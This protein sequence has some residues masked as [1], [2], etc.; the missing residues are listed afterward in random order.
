[1]KKLTI[2][3]IILFAVTIKTKAQ[4]AYFDGSG[5]RIRVLDASPVNTSAVPAAYQVT[6]KAI[7][8]EAWIYPM[9]L[10]GKSDAGIL[11]Y[12]PSSNPEPYRSF[13]LRVD[14]W[15]SDNDDPRIQWIISDGTVPVNWGATLDPNKPV[16]GSWTHVAGTYDGSKLC[17]YIN[18]NLVSQSAYSSD[19]GAGA[20]GLY[21]GGH[22]S[23]YFNGLIDEVRLW[24]VV[25]SQGQIQASMN[26]ILTGSETGLVGYWPMD[27]DYTTDAGLKAV[28][29]KTANHNDLLVQ[30]DAKLVAFPQGVQPQLPISI[31]TYSDWYAV[32]GIK[33]SS[34]LNISG[35]PTPT[36]SMLTK[37][38][39]MV[40]TGDSLFWTPQAYQSKWNEVF[41]Q[42]NNN[43][44]SR[45]KRFWV[46]VDQLTK[47]QNQISLDV[48]Y[49]GNL[50]GMGKYAKGLYYKSLNGLYSA[51]FSLVDRL[52]QKFAGCL[53]NYG[54][55]AFVPIDVFTT[56]SSRFPGFTAFRNT[57]VDSNEKNRM[58]VQVVQTIHSSTA[59]N[60]DKYAI[61]EYQVTNQSGT[62]IPDLF[63][64]LTADFDIGVSS[65]NLGG[66][67]PTLKLTYL[68]ES[69]GAT[70]PYYYGFALLNNP[71]SG[72]SVFNWD[73][74][75]TYI[76]S[77]DKLT[78]IEPNPTTPAEYRNQLN[79]GPYQ[80]AN[81]ASRTFAFALLAGDELNDIKYSATRAANVF[82]TY[83]ALDEVVTDNNNILSLSKNYP[84]PFNN[85]TK[86]TYTIAHP[87][88]ASLKVFD[89]QGK[90]VA[91][92]FN[93]FVASGTYSATIKASNIPSGMY[94]YKLESEGFVVTKRLVVMK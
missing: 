83:T 32:T 58:G 64:Q 88:I 4:S 43:S 46:Y 34:G 5:D 22:T 38:S 91:V 42:A 81:G 17:L 16:V 33:F 71:V 59:T 82:N 90:E 70:N 3:L 13:E 35:W 72:A 93:Q 67:D 12:R 9:K 2:I 84:N 94:I 25:R 47:A 27:A 68:Y 44:N 52:T 73:Y 65:N 39:G 23:Q 51:N 76:R 15:W 40:L 11:V 48:S 77:L 30:Y 78:A 26:Q 86:I 56:V 62:T 66:Y 89:L 10:P 60:D 61:L 57:L 50:G 18:G 69:G 31:P 24:N 87:G 75:S 79:T 53:Y 85:E 54:D 63:A 36:I 19:I 92:V 28:A 8:V 37:P 49:T 6:G 74:D 20:T 1:M 41:M 80:L 14:N 29:D 21:I 55:S 7:T 45:N